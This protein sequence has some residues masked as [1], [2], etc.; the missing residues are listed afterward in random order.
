MRDIKADLAAKESEMLK[1]KEFIEKLRNDNEICERRLQNAENLLNLL[2]D[3]GKR[4]EQTVRD[5]ESD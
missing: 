1:T 2:S 3:E 4:W 5:L